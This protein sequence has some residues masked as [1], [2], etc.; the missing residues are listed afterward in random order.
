M[1]SKK[2]E[3]SEKIKKA[4]LAYLKKHD[5]NT[6]HKPAGADRRSSQNGGNSKGGKG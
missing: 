5:V 1:S 4:L 2:K 3:Y 6:D